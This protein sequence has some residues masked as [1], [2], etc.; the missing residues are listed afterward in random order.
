[1]W[2]GKPY[3]FFGDYLWEKYGRRVLKLPI[4]AGLSCPNRDGSI[5]SRG[6][7]FC[8]P[9]GSAS[10]TTDVGPG[11]ITQME[12]ARR[13]FRRSDEDTRYIAYFQAFTNTYAPPGTL[14]RLYDTAVA[15]PDIIGLM[16]G[17]RPDCL[18]DEVIDLIASYRKENFELW[19]ELGMQ[20]SHDR[21]L[22]FLNRG[23]TQHST[24]EAVRRTAL[25]GLDICL[26]I[27]LGIP[28]ETW[29]DMMRTAET[30]SS[31]PVQ[32]VKFH[33]LHVIKGTH[34]EDMHRRGE[35]PLLSL[36]EYVST[37]C[38]FMERLRPDI[39]IHRLAGDRDTESLVAPAWGAHKGTVQNAI[40]DE[41][42]KRGT[43]QGFLTDFHSW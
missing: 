16:I 30:I 42:R 7:L 5:S 33:H 20:S 38:D 11:I 39:I 13:M 34:L 24:A 8:S 17:T 4:N 9:E 40:E 31:L 29:D 1:M 36:K 25:R 28:G 3:R 15:A 10:P 21:S 12:N 22:D 19:I 18:P 27:I 23:H 41:F 32:G 43:H 2:N 6:C 14:K 35:V 37:V 26:H